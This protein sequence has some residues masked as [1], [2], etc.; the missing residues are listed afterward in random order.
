MNS[1]I[2]IGT[3]IFCSIKEICK[4]LK[5]GFTNKFQYN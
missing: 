5:K 4:K 1:N 3:E 2:L